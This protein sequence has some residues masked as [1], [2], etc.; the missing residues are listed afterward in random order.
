MT[1]PVVKHILKVGVLW[2]DSPKQG[3]DH[4]HATAVKPFRHGTKPLFIPA[5]CCLPGREGRCYRHGAADVSKTEETIRW[6]SLRYFGGKLRKGNENMSEQIRWGGKKY[7]SFILLD[8]GCLVIANFFAVL[9]Y[10]AVGDQT[11]T[12]SDYQMAMIAMS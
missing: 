3:H 4:P 11:Y 2:P 9:L 12:L 8:L 5:R 10:Q 6:R 7:F 1:C